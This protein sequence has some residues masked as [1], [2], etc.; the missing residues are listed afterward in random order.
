M[1]ER[2]YAAFIA[3]HADTVARKGLLDTEE[4]APEP[5]GGNVVAMAAARR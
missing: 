1:I 2:T 5:V 3:D 4:P